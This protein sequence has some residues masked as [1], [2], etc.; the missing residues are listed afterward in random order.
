MGAGSVRLSR[1]GG[2]APIKQQLTALAQQ[3]TQ[4]QGKVERAGFANL[5]HQTDRTI[6]EIDHAG[7]QLD[8]LATTPVGVQRK[9]RFTETIINYIGARLLDAPSIL[10]QNLSSNLPLSDNVIKAA[11][12]VVDTRDKFFDRQRSDEVKSVYDYFATYQAQPAVL[13]TEYYHTLP[14]TYSPAT[15]T[16]NLARMIITSAR[17]GAL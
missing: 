16:S 7:D 4:T 1:G 13:L 11:S 6:G 3:L 10:N 8:L 14:N 17:R 12:R 5:I 15:V 9:A 2:G